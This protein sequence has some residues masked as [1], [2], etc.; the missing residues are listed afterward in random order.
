MNAPKRWSEK[1]IALVRAAIIN[2]VEDVMF[3][4]NALKRS[5]GSIHCKLGRERMTMGLEPVYTGKTIGYNPQ[6][7]ISI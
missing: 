5:E 2:N 4:S 1:E 6:P 3:L 7:K